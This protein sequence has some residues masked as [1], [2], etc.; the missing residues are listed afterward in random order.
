MA[1][2]IEKEHMNV[3]ILWHNYI[4]K[5]PPPPSSYNMAYFCFWKQNSELRIIYLTLYIHIFLQ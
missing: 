3:S 5:I 2:M 4:P 1:Y